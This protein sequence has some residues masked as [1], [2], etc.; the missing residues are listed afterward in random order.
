MSIPAPD[1]DPRA[2]SGAGQRGGVPEPE[3]ATPR[4]QQPDSKSPG[5]QLVSPTPAG[6]VQFDASEHGAEGLAP[7]PPGKVDPAKVVLGVEL[8]G[9]QDPKVGGGASESSSRDLEAEAEVAAEAREPSLSTA[10]ESPLPRRKSRKEL[11]QQRSNTRVLTRGVTRV[12]E[13]TARQRALDLDRLD[14][15]AVLIETARADG[16]SAEIGYR[17]LRAELAAALHVSEHAVEREL[18]LAYALHSRY[19]ST[20]DVL[21]AGVISMAHVRVICDA[22][23]IIGSG[24]EALVKHALYEAAVLQYAVEETP[25]RLRPI[26]KRIAEEYA[27]VS[28]EQR[29]ET[30]RKQRR[31]D[32]VEREDGMAELY[33]LLPA[34]VAWAIKDRLHR[35]AKAAWRTESNEARQ[36][37]KLASRQEASTV[38]HDHNDGAVEVVDVNDGPAGADGLVGAVCAVGAVGSVSFDG[39]GCSDGREIPEEPEGVPRSLDEVRADTLADLLLNGNPYID[40]DLTEGSKPTTADLGFFAHVQ[41]MVPVATLTPPDPDDLD[42]SLEGLE[43]P[44]Q[45]C[46]LVGYG[47]ISSLVAQELLE[48]SRNI[49]RVGVN[50]SGHVLSIDRY[51]PSK[52]MKR[53]LKA[54]DRRCRFP[55]CARPPVNCDI[56]HTVDW[57]HD[58]LTATNNLEHLCRNHH[59][60]KHHT[61]WR[62]VQDATGTLEWTSPAGRLHV[63]RPP[64][65]TYR[66][67]SAASGGRRDPGRCP[68]GAGERDCPP[69]PTPTPTSTSTSTSTSPN[70]Q[71]EP[72]DKIRNLAGSSRRSGEGIGTHTFKGEREKRR[73]TTVQFTEDNSAESR[74]T[75]SSSTESNPTERIFT[76]S[77]TDGETL[78]DKDQPF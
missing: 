7:A 66:S 4:D 10:T 71:A 36:A 50:A 20:R 70:V 22:G 28:L 65:R 62:P 11:R 46:E 59:T 23:L 18:D 9:E 69:T 27:E 38:T 34:E 24:D 56:D 55:G 29:H 54:R 44:R 6:T 13:I 60:L 41:V 14:E 8:S 74:S 68:P 32:I 58:G 37:V 67:P 5:P 48:H 33:A 40:L 1:S 16:S 51:K 31:V 15:Y 64:G 63:D 53:F 35:I 42:A 2:S 26:A 12:E 77:R 43:E 49:T 72:L 25:G 61:D 30:A 19:L 52:A 17:S 3:E 78:R 21:G 39:A 76:E 73:G 57:Q 45:V 47:P 75:E